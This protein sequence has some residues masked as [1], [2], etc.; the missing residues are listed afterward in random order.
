VED[1]RGERGH[2]QAVIIPEQSDFRS[3]WADWRIHPVGDNSRVVYEAQVTPAFFIPPI[4][5]SY[6]VKRTFGEA[7]MTSFAKLECIARLRAELDTRSRQYLADATPD[8]RDLDA[9]QAAMRPAR[10]PQAQAPAGRRWQLRSGCSGCPGTCDLQ[11]S[12]VDHGYRSPS[13][14]ASLIV[15]L[16]AALPNKRSATSRIL[17][18]PGD[19]LP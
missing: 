2:L 13:W 8:A 5:G 11:G 10:I 6:F 17:P 16:T 12:G 9:I 3:G 19:Q 4:I 1:V 7:I 14:A 15:L 18:D